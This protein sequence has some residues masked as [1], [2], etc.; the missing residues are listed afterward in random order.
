MNPSPNKLQSLCQGKSLEE[1]WR[2]PHVKAAVNLLRQHYQ[3]KV[4]TWASRD[5]KRHIPV[6]ISLKPKIS[7]HGLYHERHR[8]GGSITLFPI[9]ALPYQPVQEVLSD[10]RLEEVLLHEYAH[11]LTGTAHGR[12]FQDNLRRATRAAK[13]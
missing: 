6:Y 13:M 9:K 4:N 2:S 10:A 5:H 1:I 11:H 8:G 12:N 7:L 3:A